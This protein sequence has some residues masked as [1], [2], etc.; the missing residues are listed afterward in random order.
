VLQDIALLPGNTSEKAKAIAEIARD[1]IK[2]ATSPKANT[3]PGPQQNTY[4]SSTQYFKIS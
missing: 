2:K 4:K 3:T 1:L